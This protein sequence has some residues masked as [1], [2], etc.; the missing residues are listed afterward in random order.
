MS[1]SSPERFS[2]LRWLQN[3][4]CIVTAVGAMVVIGMGVVGFGSPSGTSTAWMIVA[5]GFTLFL[6]VAAMTT[7]PLVLKME[8]ILTPML[9]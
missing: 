1:G 2:Q 9:R 3:V 6:A 4:A 5:G 7:F 8:S